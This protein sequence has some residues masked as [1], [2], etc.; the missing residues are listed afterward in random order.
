MSTYLVCFAV[1][2]FEFVERTSNKGIPVSLLLCVAIS[3]TFWN[4]FYAVKHIPILVCFVLQLRIYAQ[5]SQLHTA[6]YAANTTK[7]IFDYFEDY[8]N[9]SYSLSKLG[10][11]KETFI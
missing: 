8:F 7:I 6:E 2:Q 10:T 11:L 5:P 4:L 3:T 1:H 9:M